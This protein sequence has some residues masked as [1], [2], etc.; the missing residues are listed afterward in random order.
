MRIRP[1]PVRATPVHLIPDFPGPPYSD[2][3]TTGGR[4]IEHGYPHLDTVR[5]ALHA[6]FKRLSYDTVRTFD[7]S[8]LPVDVAFDEDEDLH[9]GAQRWPVPWSGSCI[10]RTR[11]W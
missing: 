4:A 1:T 8:V 6:L 2:R 5:S 7:T 3:V 9:L 10:C 11:G